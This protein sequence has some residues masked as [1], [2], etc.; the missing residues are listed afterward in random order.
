M[1]SSSKTKVASFFAPELLF[2]DFRINGDSPSS[3]AHVLSPGFLSSCGIH[4]L[5]WRGFLLRWLFS[6]VELRHAFALH[7]P[8]FGLEE[9]DVRRRAR[10]PGPRRFPCHRAWVF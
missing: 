6:G 3:D 10:N 1:F 7:P 5:F 8:G 2:P 4:S 9:T